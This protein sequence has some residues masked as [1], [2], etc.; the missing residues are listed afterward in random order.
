MILDNVNNNVGELVGEHSNSISIQEPCS[1]RRRRSQLTIGNQLDDI[2]GNTYAEWGQ[3]LKGLA[4][5]DPVVQSLLDLR[6]GSKARRLKSLKQKKQAVI[7]EGSS[8]AHNEYFDSS[9]NDSEATLYSSRLNELEESVNETDD[10]D[11]P[12]MDLSD[13]N[14]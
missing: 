9:D 10:V 12:D 13:D 3:K 6:E 14:P 5:D 1:Q 4:D 7:G 8:V 2:V 11:E